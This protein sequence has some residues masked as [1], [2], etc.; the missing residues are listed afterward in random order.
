VS[1]AGDLDQVKSWYKEIFKK[2][3]ELHRYQTLEQ[4]T[5]EDHKAAILHLFKKV[6][7]K[8]ERIDEF[9]SERDIHW[10]ENKS[11]LKSLIVKTFQDYE[12]E[13][14]PPYE[15]REVSRNE[16]EDLVFFKELFEETL[17]QDEYL[18]EL[19]AKRIKN[20]DISRV[21]MIDLIILKMAITEMMIFPSIPVKVTINEFIEVSKQY[22]T[23]KSKQFVNGVLDVLANELTSEGVIK[24]SGRG[25]IDNK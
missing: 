10:V 15:L 11:I 5:A 2:D 13:L 17:K 20:W 24:K 23:P 9:M 12:P 18:D 25:L 19:I 21:A 22:S 16:E 4:P 8:D 3:E 14:D 6:I 1:W 7:F